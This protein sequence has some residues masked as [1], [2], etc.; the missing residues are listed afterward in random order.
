MGDGFGLIP[1]GHDIVA[2]V[3]VTPTLEVDPKQLNLLDQIKENVTEP[4]SFTND[5]LDEINY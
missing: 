3:A 1:T 5:E 2:P 4:M